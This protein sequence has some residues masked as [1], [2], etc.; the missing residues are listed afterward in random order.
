MPPGYWTSHNR[1]HRGGLAAGLAGACLL[2]LVFG[3]AAQAEGLRSP[4]RAALLPSGRLLVTDHDLNA[5]VVWDARRGRMKRLIGIPGRPVGIAFGWNRLFVGNEATGS[6]EV[7]NRRGRLLYLLGGEAGL[8]SRPTDIA[9]DSEQGLVF[10]SD[11][12]GRRVSVFDYRGPLLNVIPAPGAP[13]LHQP[14]GL[15]VDPARGEVLVSDFG[16][17]GMFAMQAWLRIYD[18]HGHYRGGISGG[19]VRGQFFSRPQG[20]A[21]DEEGRIYLVDSLRG[22]VL[23]FDRDT[24]QGVAV[25]GAPG[26]ARGQS[27]LPLDAVINHRKDFL[28]VTNNRNRRVEV[29]AGKGLVP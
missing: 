19:A 2:W 3:A 27:L 9:V 6:V 20:L 18:Y 29:F 7:Y 4:I 23:V 15:A 24:L 11:V 17:P 14:T 26:M 13:P 8:V 5:V 28:Y 22:Q 1:I 10:V 21:V 12:K 25:I 16:K